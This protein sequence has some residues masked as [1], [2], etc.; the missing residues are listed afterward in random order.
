MKLYDIDIADY[1]KLHFY[2]EFDI[3]NNDIKFS[4]L[5]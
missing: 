1:M 3:R 5:I 4:Y 2:F